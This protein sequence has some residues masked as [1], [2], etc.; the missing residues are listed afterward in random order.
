M[1]NGRGYYELEAVVHD[2]DC[3][4]L[5]FEKTNSIKAVDED[6]NEIDGFGYGDT[7]NNSMVTIPL[8]EY[9]KEYQII[10]NGTPVGEIKDFDTQVS[11]TSSGEINFSPSDVAEHRSGKIK[12]DMSI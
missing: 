6:G 2:A 9:G 3:H 5:S 8:L 10:V 4:V 11:F 1:P 12:V 7:S